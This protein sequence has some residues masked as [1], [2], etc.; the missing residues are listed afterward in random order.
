M[1][2]ETFEHALEHAAAQLLVAAQTR[3][4]NE[5][6]EMQALAARLQIASVGLTE[7]GA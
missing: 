6:Q 3:Q 4:G 7:P 5:S 1:D 2:R